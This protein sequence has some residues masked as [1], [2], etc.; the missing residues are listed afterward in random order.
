WGESQWIQPYP[1]AAFGDLDPSQILANFFKIPSAYTDYRDNLAPSLAPVGAEPGLATITE[2]L[3]DHLI[4]TGFHRDD[5]LLVVIVLGNGDDTSGR[6]ICRRSDGFQGPCD[7]GGMASAGTTITS[8]GSPA[9]PASHAPAGCSTGSSLGSYSSTYATSAAQSARNYYRT[10]IQSLRTNPAQVVVH[11]AVATGGTCY[12]QDSY[13]G[14]QYSRFASETGGTQQ[15]FCASQTSAMLKNI[16]QS[17]ET[18]RLDLFTVYLLTD[19]EPDEATIEVVRYP[20]GDTSRPVTISKSDT[21]GWS[22]EGRIENQPRVVT[23]AGVAMNRA[24]GWA[25]R[26]NGTARLKGNDTARV[27]YKPRGG[28]S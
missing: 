1:G 18:K 5:A 16:Q 22:Y 17:L 9:L 24:T 26:L 11:A 6:M 23:A 10:Q 4:G 7:A 15:N 3:K 12:S 19:V 20:G 2:Q 21:N 28:G 8:C 27:V 13:T 14:Y 25:V